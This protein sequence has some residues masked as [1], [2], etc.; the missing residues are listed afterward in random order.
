MISYT[1]HSYQSS[2]INQM[3]LSF[4][5]FEFETY[6]VSNIEA[7]PDKY[8][9]EQEDFKFF[10][11]SKNQHGVMLVIMIVPKV[12]QALHLLLQDPH[13][14]VLLTKEDLHLLQWDLHHLLLQVS[15]PLCIRI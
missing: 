9:V 15:H 5:Y 14:V 10:G 7:T 6:K 1:T 3:Q 4:A 11:A 2:T 12:L 8:L 13:L